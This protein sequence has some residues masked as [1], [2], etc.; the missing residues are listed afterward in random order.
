MAARI[1]DKEEGGKVES[2]QVQQIKLIETRQSGKN[3]TTKCK[4][5][6]LMLKQYMMKWN[7]YIVE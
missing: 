7:V 6:N 1:S 2:R 5:A 3:D 4:Q